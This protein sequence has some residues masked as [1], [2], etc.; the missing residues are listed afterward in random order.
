MRASSLRAA[1]AKQHQAQSPSR[2]AAR[3]PPCPSPAQAYADEGQLLA[4]R[5]EVAPLQE[6]G[7]LDL[8]YD[9][10][11]WGEEGVKRWAGRG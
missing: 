2:S 5:E 7:G 9:G 1:R 8:P 10:H 3:E 11:A 6:P 4:D